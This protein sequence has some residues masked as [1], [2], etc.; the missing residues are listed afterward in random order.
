MDYRLCDTDVSKQAIFK[1]QAVRK[2]D[3]TIRE[4]MINV[5]KTSLFLSGY[6]DD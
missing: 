4:S 1:V 2:L 3:D 5:N 6:D